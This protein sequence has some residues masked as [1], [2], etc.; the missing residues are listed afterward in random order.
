MAMGSEGH[1]MVVNI[2]VW[3]TALMGAIALAG[4]ALSR[5]FKSGADGTVLAIA[6]GILLMVPFAFYSGEMYSRAYLYILPALAYFGVR[7]LKTKASALILLVLL[8]VALPLSIISIH[9][10]QAM[11]R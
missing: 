3:F 5:K 11:G 6:G 9:G 4:L 8:L 10:N 7:L 1:L 2:R